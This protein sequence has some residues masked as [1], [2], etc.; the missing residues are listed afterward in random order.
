MLPLLL[1]HID[2][3]RDRITVIDTIDYRSMPL[4]APAIAEGV[5]FVQEQITRDRYAQQLAA[6]VGPG[7]MIIDLAW[8]IGCTDILAWCHEH[9]VLYINT[10]VELW[11]PYGNFER[12][13]TTDRTLYVRHMAI[14]KMVRDWGGL[15]G[16]TA[17][18]EHGA[19]PGLVSHFT[20]RALIDIARK[21]LSEK[22]R[23]PRIADLK[24]ALVDNAYNRLAQLL[25]VKVIHIS[26]IDTQITDRPGDTDEFVNTWSV[27]GFHEE[28]TAPAELGWGTHER[29]LPS[30]ARIHVSGPR[31]QICLAR[32]GINT[33]VR[34]RVPSREIVGM[35]V[36]HGEAFTISDYLTVLGEDGTPVYRPTV[37]Y[38]YCPCAAAISSLHALR[39]RHYQMQ[40]KFRIMNDDIL[41]GGGDELGCLLMGHDFKS[42]WAGTILSIDETRRLVPGQ[43]ATTLQVAASVLG[44]IFWMIRHPRKGVLVPDQLPHEE[45]M[46]VADPYLGEVVSMPLDWTPHGSDVTAAKI[47]NT[48]APAED[49][50]WQFQHF[51]L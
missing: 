10:S 43:N 44:A 37:H 39:A 11:D 12:T 42:W 23:D 3:P 47:R 9:D 38:A 49:D 8:N 22:P 4:L 40:E 29:V 30:D 48:F 34:S 26:E 1:R 33:F 31:N 19:N 2:M 16:A 45:I 28:G 41:E 25:S 7:D 21:I 35:V 32:Y 20:K 15:P 5:R 14:R 24:R 46:Q 6:Y 36:R 51:L 18:L 50:P 17:V 13:S 27:Q